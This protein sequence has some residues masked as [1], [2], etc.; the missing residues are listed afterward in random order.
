[1]AFTYKLE[2]PDGTPA[3]PPTFRA[4]IPTWQ[5]GDTIYLAPVG[6]SASPIPGSMRG[7]T[8]TRPQLSSSRPRKT[9]NSVAFVDGSGDI[10]D[11]RLKSRG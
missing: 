4:A 7:R 10:I 6:R 5:S 11:G 1:M 3:D 9:A 8:A 2:H